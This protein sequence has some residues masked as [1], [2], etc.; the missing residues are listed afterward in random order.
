MLLGGN[1]TDHRP[2]T[3]ATR[4]RLLALGPLDIGGGL[5]CVHVA[6]EQRAAVA[7]AIARSVIGP[8]PVALEGTVEIA[9]RLVA[10]GS[11]P[12][13][14]LRPSASA[15]IDR[16]YLDTVWREA[17]AR[18]RGD[19]EAAHAARRLDRHRTDAAIE[20]ARQR[21]IAAAVPAA[22][23]EPEPRPEP[24]PMLD[25]VTPELER[26]VTALTDLQPV[27]SP[28]ALALA[29]AFDALAAEP[30]HAPVDI[31]LTAIER[32]VA[33]ARVE[34]AHAAGGVAPD[35]RKR[36]EAAHRNVVDTERAVYEAGRKEKP[37]AVDA[38]Q[39]AR[40]E[41]DDALQQGGVESYAS[42]LVAIA[43]GAV[44]VDLEARLRAEII[45]AEAEQALHEARA[46]HHETLADDREERLLELRARAAQMLGHFPSDDAPGELRALRV[47]HP[48]AAVIRHELRAALAAIGVEGDDIERLA[49]DTIRARKDAPAPSVL[50]E[51][52]AP[53]PAPEPVVDA[54]T[55][56]EIDALLRERADRE[57][58]LAA[59]ETELEQLDRQSAMPFGA[60]LPDAAALAVNEMLDRYR[61][62]E[63]LAGRLPLVL[64]GA[65]DDLASPV[66]ARL[67]MQLAAVDD[68]QVI[69]VTADDA[70]STVMAS[71]EAPVLA[72]PAELAVT[73]AAMPA[74]ESDV[75]TCRAHPGAAP[76]ANCVH[77]GR[78]SC[79]DC[80]AYVPGAND[81]WCVD[82]ADTLSHRNLRLLRRRGA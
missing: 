62:S 8:R 30:P 42:Y 71:V 24:E 11:L 29:D 37:V 80:L 23:P 7:E 31:D 58:A 74:V 15:T 53:A 45:L 50:L 34:V 32:R 51:P 40:S 60:L 4:L 10:L 47:P 38:Y 73:A 76:A 70:L 1:Q 17:C 20:R 26:L 19:L 18:R 81:L 36:I 9:G 54:A 77:C 25:A 28:D 22:A 48:D 3:R 69:V 41:L 43:A 46:A 64:D 13:P 49:R 33:A 5:S 14:L 21:A 56:A 16:A 66:A 6:P 35:A 78:P 27:A 44:P 52:A 2:P 75:T 63:L 68:V 12:A 59:L 57:D 39:S 67:A 55:R 82:C 61:A 79:M 72:W 65:F